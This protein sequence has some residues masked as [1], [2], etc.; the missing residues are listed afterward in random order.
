[1]KIAVFPGSFDPIT[2]AHVDIVERGQRLFDK[3]YVAVGVNQTKKGHFSTAERL[4]V[5]EEVFHGNSRVEAMQFTGL[6]VD[7]CRQVSAGYILRGM[8]NTLDF[9]YEQAI[10]G[11][12]GMLAP[13]IETVFLISRSGLSHISSTIIRE[14]MANN[15]DISQLVP[16]AVQQAYKRR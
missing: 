14:I 4:A 10:A 12:N 16:L 13:D 8:R 3:I 9:E 15:G 2:N 6:T 11:N 1:M 5:I 7:L